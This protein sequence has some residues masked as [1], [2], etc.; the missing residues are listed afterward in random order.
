MSID[1]ST[2][3]LDLS[4]NWTN[5]SVILTCTEKSASALATISG[6]LWFNEKE[7]SIYCFRGDTPD[8]TAYDYQSYLN[9]SR[10]TSQFHPHS[11]WASTLDGNGTANWK[12]VIGP[13]GPKPFPPGILPGDGP[14]VSS[15][16]SHGYFNGGF[17]RNSTMPR[18]G[19]ARAIFT[20]NFTDLTI[21]NTSDGANDEFSVFGRMVNV[22][23]FGTSGVLILLG[24]DPAITNFSNIT[25]YDTTKKK[26]YLQK[27]AG[28]I[29]TS[30]RYYFCLAGIRGIESDTF[31]M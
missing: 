29:P 6:D 28:E 9:H 19:R 11:I 20:V 1:N 2:C 3:G 26:W 17:E 4:K 16:E 15:D 30:D 7:N 22:P 31:E 27:A 10:T 23:Y 8:G 21:T 14:A 12:E 13:T 5:T 25:I 24:K 18:A